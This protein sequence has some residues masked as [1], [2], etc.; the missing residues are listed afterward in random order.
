MGGHAK[1]RVF[2]I[3]TATIERV[4]PLLESARVDFI[5]TSPIFT[6]ESR[7]FTASHSLKMASAMD[8]L[9]DI[10]CRFCFKR[11]ERRDYTRTSNFRDMYKKAGGVVK[12]AEK[13]DTIEL[14]LPDAFGLDSV[15]SPRADATWE[16]EARLRYAQLDPTCVRFLGLHRILNSSL[17]DPLQNWALVAIGTRSNPF[18]DS[19]S[20]SG[21]F[22]EEHLEK[23]C[24]PLVEGS[25]KFRSVDQFHSFSCE[26]C[27]KKG[28]PH[29]ATNVHKLISKRAALKLFLRDE[30]HTP[31]KERCSYLE[32]NFFFRWKCTPFTDSPA[33]TE[34]PKTG[35][36][37]NGGF[38]GCARPSE[39]VMNAQNWMNSILGRARDVCKSSQDLK[40]HAFPEST[41][42]VERAIRK[43]N[44]QYQGKPPPYLN[45]DFQ[46]TLK[47][48]F[49][50][51]IEEGTATSVPHR[52]ALAE[53]HADIISTDLA[54]FC[55]ND[56]NH[57]CLRLDQLKSGSG[58]YE[59]V[60]TSKQILLDSSQAQIRIEKFPKLRAIFTD[61]SGGQLLPPIEL[62][63]ISDSWL[64][65]EGDPYFRCNGCVCETVSDRKVV[66]IEKDPE[67]AQTDPNKKFYKFDKWK[68]MQVI[69]TINGD[70][71]SCKIEEVISEFKVRLDRAIPHPEDSKKLTLFIEYPLHILAEDLR[72]KIDMND[73]DAKTHIPI[74]Q[75]LRGG[76]Y[77]MSQ[78]LPI[79][80]P[81]LYSISAIFSQK[82]NDSPSVR[83]YW[84][85]RIA[86]NLAGG[87]AF[88]HFWENSGN[89]PTLTQPWK[90]STFI[91]KGNN[92][93]IVP[94]LGNCTFMK[95]DDDCCEVGKCYY[96][97]DPDRCIRHCKLDS[98]RVCSVV[99]PTAPPSWVQA[100]RDLCDFI[101]LVDCVTDAGQ[102]KW[103]LHF[104]LESIV[105]PSH[106]FPPQGGVMFVSMPANL[107]KVQNNPPKVLG[108][109]GTSSPVLSIDIIDRNFANKKSFINGF[110]ETFESLLISCLDGRICV[111]SCPRVPTFESFPSGSIPAS[112]VPAAPFLPVA[113]AP[114]PAPQKGADELKSFET[115]RSYLKEQL[116][117]S[118][119][120]HALFNGCVIDYLLR[121]DFGAP[122]TLKGAICPKVGTPSS[123]FPPGI[124]DVFV[125]YLEHCLP[126]TTEQ[127]YFLSQCQLMVA[128]HKKSSLEQLLL[129]KVVLIVMNENAKEKVKKGKQAAAHP[130]C[131]VLY[132]A[133]SQ[134]DSKIAK[135]FFECYLEILQLQQAKASMRGL[136]SVP[137]IT[138][139]N[140]HR[141]IRSFLIDNPYRSNMEEMKRTLLA[142]RNKVAV[143]LGYP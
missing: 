74:L 64:Y 128:S 104:E 80:P 46:E 130:L 100:R 126:K 24:A 60:A 116:Q 77:A 26:S 85:F 82:P 1:A 51:A 125:K 129:R 119:Q 142:V 88:H 55:K 40:G 36:L 108:F 78:D 31:E 52:K 87:P 47:K 133:H 44:E 48:V 11:C 137:A 33:P 29:S 45:P 140:Y 105:S 22:C 63:G 6:T 118:S 135:V 107:G 112:V 139:V 143:S 131:G 43:L 84:K 20:A 123:R 110:R 69:A 2:K 61:D 90:S 12:R 53:L 102:A 115:L 59:C 97:F 32:Q 106:E 42:V 38:L 76:D 138:A 56:Q 65:A 13:E 66:I 68:N 73:G 30:H 89:S 67:A 28:T 91:P 25:D 57:H 35:S 41:S 15:D 103:G 114:L 7:L 95:E 136:G 27:F 34:K 122:V 92:F 54:Q 132:N 19:W 83:Q 9:G 93:C 17:R 70:P 94:P 10:E 5:R 71:F 120:Q 86:S 113:A 23:A 81:Q 4:Q 109:V 21:A 3:R 18:P 16:N 121:V 111:V 50:L 141:Y 75:V 39:I 117:D 134:V 58:F 14:A 79:P 101:P 96:Y 62:L 99:A 98:C 127:K 37:E 72:V 8:M 124:A 49:Q